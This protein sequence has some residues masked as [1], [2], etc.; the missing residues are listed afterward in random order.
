MNK[1]EL[2]IHPVRLRIL[3]DI[4]NGASTTQEI[5]D[6]L[7]DVPKSSVYRHIKLLLEGDL[8]AVAD[9]RLVNGIQEKSYQITQPPVLGPGDV[10]LWTAEDHV[11][12][13]TTYV[14]TLLH[15]YANYVSRTE[16]EQGV[17]DM[18]ADRVGYREVNFFATPQELDVTIGEMGAALMPL[19]KKEAG[20]GRR[21]YKLATVLHPF[22]EKST[23]DLPITSNE[24][25]R[26]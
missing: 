21:R 1:A 17:I 25:D 7:G 26:I 8:V 11:S 12:Y 19:L 16:A 22:I 2:I 6:R 18:L 13:F 10:A 15:D 5:A 23:P 14:L 24:D 20:N 4:G 3:R 9:T